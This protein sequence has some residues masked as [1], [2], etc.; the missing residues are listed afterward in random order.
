QAADSAPVQEV[1]VTAARVA[2]K[3]PDTLP[4]TTVINRADIEA[5]PATDLPGLLSGLTRLSVAQAG[6][7]AS[8]TSVFMRGAN[9][10][11]VLVLVDGVPV[12]RADAGSS[13]WELLP[14]GQIDH[15]EIVRGNMSSLYG[16]DAVG[17]VIQIF[18]KG[19]DHTSLMV[20]AGSR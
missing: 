5:A 6:P 1:V 20:G 17:G 10:G 9:S 8:Q 15:I 11:Q 4:S 18:T 14:L 13:P 7:F 3:L 16:S 19:G 2:Q 12:T